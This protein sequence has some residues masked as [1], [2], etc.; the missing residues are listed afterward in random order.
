[1]IELLAALALVPWAHPLTFRPLSGWHTGASGTVNSLYDNASKRVRVPKES[2]AWMATPDVRYRDPATEDPPN[3]TL[4]HL[5][6][7]AVIVWAVIFQT[8]RP[9]QKPI[10]LELRH[11]RHFACCEGAYV[12]GGAYELSGRGPGTGYSVIVRVYFA[13]HPTR[14]A[15]AQAQRA[16][17][18]LELPPLR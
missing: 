11:A 8:E 10:R 4:A 16:L 12:A 1:V 13:S 7:N 5:P 6:R 14:A 18:R 17:D 9:A 15:R 2:A 3:R